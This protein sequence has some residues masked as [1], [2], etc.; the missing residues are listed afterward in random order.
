[1]DKARYKRRVRSGKLSTVKAKYTCLVKSVQYVL[2]D[3][4]VERANRADTQD[5]RQD[6]HVLAPA[7][8]KEKGK[9]D[10]KGDKGKGKR[11][12]GGGDKGKGKGKGNGNVGN[13][14]RGGGKGKDR[15][16]PARRSQSRPEGCPDGECWD[17][18]K[19]GSCERLKPLAVHSNTALA[20]LPQPKIRP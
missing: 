10:G 17:N 4:R 7:Q 11:G 20:Q 18:Y 2:E 6:T 1:M 15:E 13:K 12:G 8:G 3:A 14:G 19:H 16:Y 9:G 5:L